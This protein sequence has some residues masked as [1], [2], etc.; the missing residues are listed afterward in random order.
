[1]AYLNEVLIFLSFSR[2]KKVNKSKKKDASWYV[3]CFE[4]IMVSSL[5]RGSFLFCLCHLLFCLLFPSSSTL[6]EISWSNLTLE[7]NSSWIWLSA[8]TPM[9]VLSTLVYSELALEYW[10]K[11]KSKNYFAQVSNLTTKFL[12]VHLPQKRAKWAELAVQFS[13]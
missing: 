11:V 8:G 5:H 12:S 13:W 6:L 9:L 4:I 7:Q 1:M 10:Q 3:I 2:G